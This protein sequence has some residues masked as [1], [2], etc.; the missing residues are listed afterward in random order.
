MNALVYYIVAIF[1]TI[2][3]IYSVASQGFIIIVI[4]HILMLRNKRIS[5]A[6]FAFVASTAL[7]INAC[8]SESLISSENF[9][10]VISGMLSKLVIYLFEEQFKE[11]EVKK[12]NTNNVIKSFNQIL[13]NIPSGIL[14]C[15]N[16]GVLKA[17]K[18]WFKMQKKLSH[19]SK[20]FDSDKNIYR[21]NRETREAV[22]NENAYEMLKH[23][24][25]AKSNQ[26]SLHDIVRNIVGKGNTLMVNPLQDFFK[27]FNSSFL[28]EFKDGNDMRDEITKDFTRNSA[29]L[30]E[31]T[32]VCN[33]FNPPKEYTAY[34]YLMLSDE[35]QDTSS[36]SKPK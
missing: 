10:V 11:K 12:D 9:E 16:Q 34:I 14:F 26:I 1:I 3:K 7:I 22:E 17:N 32:V 4:S 36:T 23:F 31:V 18:F 8:F 13:D 2:D 33:L 28:E 20:K 5:D 30:Q 27:V 35:D 29:H 21:Y 15:S 6:F 19:F 25:C 24:R